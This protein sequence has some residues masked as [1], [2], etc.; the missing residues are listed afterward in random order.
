MLVAML[1]HMSVGYVLLGVLLLGLGMY[2]WWD[3][4]L[5]SGQREA[6]AQRYQ[7]QVQEYLADLELYK[8]LWIC[9]D[10]GKIFIPVDK[11]SNCVAN[12]LSAPEQARFLMP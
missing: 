4:Q 7:A 1:G 9:L 8:K 2:F 11:A 12:G 6:E 3:G 10:C 5:S